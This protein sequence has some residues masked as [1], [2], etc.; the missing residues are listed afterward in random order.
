MSI[1]ASS[2]YANNV[3]TMIT[4]AS[5]VSRLTITPQQPRA[6]TLSVVDYTWGAT[7]RVDTLAARMYG[8]ETMW[9]VIAQGNPQIFDWT[10]I[11]AG[12]RIRI[13]NAIG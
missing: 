10:L 11:P 7:D 1:S 2:R 3:T 4:D 8:D 6:N 13:P 9:W 5:G 12:T